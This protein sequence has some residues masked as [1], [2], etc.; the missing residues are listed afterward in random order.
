MITLGGEAA[1][2][3]FRRSLIT[4]YNDVY[5]EHLFVFAA[6][7]SYYFVLSLF[8]LLVSLASLLAYI[9][10][11]HLFEGLLSLMARLVPGDGMSLVR[12]IVSDVVRDKHSHFLTLG[13][14]FTVWTASSGFAAIIDGL[15]VVYRIRETRPVW[16]TRPIALGLTLLAGSLLLVAV[17][18]MVEGTSF[19]VWAVGRFDL[20]PVSFAAWRYVRG[21]V[22]TAFAILAVELVYHYGPDVKRRFRDSLAGAIVA[23]MTWIGLSYLFGLY[24][25]H[26]DSLDLTYGPLGAAIGLYVWFYL[27]GFAVLVGGEINFLL[28]ELRKG[29]NLQSLAPTRSESNDLNA[30]A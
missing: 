5:D 4:I 11:P 17:G 26:F 24:F 14:G 23:V 9:P 20:N 2:P 28:G 16:K 12:K 25:R 10:I 8:P 3:T 15:N 29:G 27:S 18:L 19:G 13:V 7:L 6:G 1:W 21:F 30:A 22:A